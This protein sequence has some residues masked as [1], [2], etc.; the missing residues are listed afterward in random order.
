M[1][2]RLLLCFTTGSIPGENEYLPT[3]FDHYEYTAEVAKERKKVSL[4]ETAGE[5][6]RG[7]SMRFLSYPMTDIFFICFPI[8]SKNLKTIMKRINFFKDEISEKMKNVPFYLVGTKNDLRDNSRVIKMC[9]NGKLK[10]LTMTEGV[11]IAQEVGAVKYIECS[12]KMNIGVKELFEDAFLYCVNIN[13]PIK[14]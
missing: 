6:Q 3:F 9:K 12:A 8:V 5:D 11:E 7:G 14:I 2:N 10:I 4:W 1:Q 13:K